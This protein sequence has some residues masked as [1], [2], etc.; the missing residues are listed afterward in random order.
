MYIELDF[1][2]DC[3]QCFSRP[4]QKYFQLIK[5]VISVLQIITDFFQAAGEGGSIL[6]EKN[7][8]CF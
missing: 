2:C 5:S 6:P 1:F 4:D 7:L 8:V 3:C